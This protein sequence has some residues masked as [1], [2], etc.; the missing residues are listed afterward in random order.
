MV[1]ALVLAA[2]VTA[3]GVAALE[4]VFNPRY[5][6]F[7]DFALTG[8]ALGVLLLALVLRPA[9]TGL[10]ATEEIARFAFLAAA[11]YIPL[12]ETLANWQAL[13]FGGLCLAVSLTVWRVLAV[14]R[15]A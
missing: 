10:S 4:L 6:D 11:I 15:T 3:V 9:R 12:N 5:K 7:P 14:Q 13:W 8:P 2:T 1:A